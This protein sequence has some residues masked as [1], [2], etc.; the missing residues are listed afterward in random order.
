MN[1]VVG[2]FDDSKQAGEAIADLKNEGYTDDI[3]IVSKDVNDQGVKTHQ[4]KQ[5]SSD[6][7]AAGAAV[8][9]VMGALAGI[10][11]GAASFALPGIGLVVLGPLAATLTGAA[12]GAATGG[13]VGA[14]VDMGIPEKRAKEYQD[15][16][17]SGQVL[18]SVTTDEDK[19]D[20]A[21][22]VLKKHGVSEAMT[23]HRTE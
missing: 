5:D 10:L 21:M 13:L 19:A 20:D 2:L 7:A 1:T 16:V 17:S 22:E 15:A 23:Y 4:V 6:G 12:A 11:A 3:S 14:L 9:S 18:V 8:G